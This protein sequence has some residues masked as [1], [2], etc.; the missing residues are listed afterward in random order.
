MDR[1]ASE[2]RHH[3]MT[4][5]MPTYRTKDEW[6]ARAHAEIG[7][8]CEHVHLPVQ[9]GSDTV[10]RRMGR[11]Y[12]RADYLAAI[13]RLS[14]ARSGTT[15]GMDVIVGFP[16]ETR[17]EF[18]ETLSLVR[19]VRP[20][21]VFSFAY[22]PRPGTPAEK[23]DDD[24]PAEEKSRRLTELQALAEEI[25]RAHLGS[26]RGKT[27]EVLVEGASDRGERSMQGRTRG[28]DIVHVVVAAGART[29]RPGEI[30][31]VRIDEA[32]PHCLRASIT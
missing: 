14:S 27:A 11:R 9:S 16:R 29:P 20:T 22:S 24:V 13:A 10:L 3:N 31:S 12:A 1:R 5:T 28:N 26:L 21:Q 17:A 18:E 30:V 19:E 2:T 15:Y 8:L 25:A 7:T 6:L 23:W 4:Y 32:L